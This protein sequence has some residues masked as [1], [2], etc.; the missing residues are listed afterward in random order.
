MSR[1]IRGTGGLSISGSP[2]RTFFRNFV[3]SMPGALSGHSQLLP[4]THGTKSL[5]L[6][7]ILLEN[8]ISPSSTNCDVLN[9][10]L[11][12]T[13]YGRPSYKPKNSATEIEFDHQALSFIILKPEIIKTAKCAYAFDTGGFK[14]GYYKEYLDSALNP[15]DFS[16][17]VADISKFITEFH[18]SNAMYFFNTI[19][20]EFNTNEKKQKYVGNVEMLNYI[21]LVNSTKNSDQRSS[22]IEICFSENINLSKEIIELIVMPDRLLDH[23]DYG[24]IAGGLGIPLKG[25][26]FSAHSSIDSH[27]SKVVDLIA[28]HYRNLGLF[29]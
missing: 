8:N 26:R 13:F 1:S 22:S 29:T 28:E 24:L 10:K 25:Y 18:G 2:G 11:I 14:N 7:D 3:T 12:F 21:N 27:Q 19:S 17:N 16:F 20:N 5:L 4:I 23:P 6:R 9:E 15:K